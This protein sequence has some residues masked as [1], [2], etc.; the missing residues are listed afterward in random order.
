MPANQSSSARL[1]S[2]LLILIVGAGYFILAKL[3]LLL[4]FESSN[5]TPVWPPSGFAFAMIL[6]F[7]YRLAPGILLGAFAANLV[8][9]YSSHTT[10]VPAAIILSAIISIGNT[11]EAL[12]GYYMLKKMMP[13][14][15][16]NQ[17]FNKV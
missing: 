1:P 5:A 14:A 15:K 16:D 6:I 10:T 8:V 17:Y 9:L 13:F 11:G 3:S 4:S 7:G 2:F 12:V